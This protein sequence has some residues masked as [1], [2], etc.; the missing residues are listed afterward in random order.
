M[1]GKECLLWIC[2]ELSDIGE[3]KQ[4]LCIQQGLCFVPRNPLW[5]FSN[6]FLPLPLFDTSHNIRTFSLGVRSFNRSSLPYL[7]YRSWIDIL[8]LVFVFVLSS[9]ARPGFFCTGPTFVLARFFL[10][11]PLLGFVAPFPYFYW[12]RQVSTPYDTLETIYWWWDLCVWGLPLHRSLHRHCFKW[13]KY[14]F[15]HF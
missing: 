4:G 11:S 9:S 14:L 3:K 12:I 8:C 13:C 5:S 2:T 7:W 6:I 15:F 1:G 10:R